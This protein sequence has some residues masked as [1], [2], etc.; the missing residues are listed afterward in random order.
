MILDVGCGKRPCGHVNTDLYLERLD[1]S[2]I[3][4]FVKSTIY[5]LPFP[6]RMFDMVVCREVLEHLDDPLSAL[7]ELIRVAKRIVIVEVPHRRDSK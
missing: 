2:R 4:N 5:A 1:P 3:R 7:K 6:D